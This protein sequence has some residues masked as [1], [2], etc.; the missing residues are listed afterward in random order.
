[1]KAKI[2]NALRVWKEIDDE[3]VP[4]LRLP[5]I[6]RTAY[7]YLLRHSRLEGKTRLRFSIPWLARGVRVSSGATRQA[8]RRLVEKGVLRLVERTKAGHVV[9]VALPEEIPTA[10]ELNGLRLARGLSLEDIDF[11]QSNELSE[12]IHARECGRCFYCLR[13]LTPEGR[14]LDH[15]VPRV[16]L[17]R[18]SFCNLVS[19]CLECNSKK[20]ERMAGD[21]L[22]WLYREGRLTSAELSARLRA[23]EALAAGKLRPA[24]QSQRNCE[25]KEPNETRRLGRTRAA[26]LFSPMDPEATLRPDPDGPGESPVEEKSPPEGIGRA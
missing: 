11:L 14:C 25:G 9:E 19:C 17:G 5:V 13:R 20:A 18:N 10:P 12:T 23:L 16:H 6:D 24:I 3:L 15:V 4:R 21:F 2:P 26:D 7:C 22:R 8:V 1:M